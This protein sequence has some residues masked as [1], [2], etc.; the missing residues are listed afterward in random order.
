MFFW[1]FLQRNNVFQHFLHHKNWSCSLFKACFSQTKPWPKL[2]F[3]YRLGG[4][5]LIFLAG[6]PEGGVLF[7]GGGVYGIMDGG[8]GGLY[9]G[10]THS[11][12]L[13]TAFVH[14]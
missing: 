6:T 5:Y 11:V 8:R 13:I 2:N 12:S 3:R 1:V 7:E 14:C 4:S 9:G 10:G